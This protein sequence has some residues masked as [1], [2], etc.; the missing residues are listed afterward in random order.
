[1]HNYRQTAGIKKDPQIKLN[2]KGRETEHV[3]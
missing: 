2:N 1:M 3:M